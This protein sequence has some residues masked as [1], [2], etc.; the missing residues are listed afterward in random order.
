MTTEARTLGNQP[1]FPTMYLTQDGKYGYAFDVQTH[2]GT[3]KRQLF[4]ALAMMGISANTGANERSVKSIAILSVEQADAL[5]EEL[6]K[7]E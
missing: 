6:S 1:A 4:A 5:L 2:E 3:T 7:N